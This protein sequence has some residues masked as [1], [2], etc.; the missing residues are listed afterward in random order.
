MCVCA[1]MT[2]EWEHSCFHTLVRG[3]GITPV[4]LAASSLISVTN[5][6]DRDYE[7]GRLAG[8]EGDL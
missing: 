4:P 5:I 8:V 1:H 3:E 7:K 2:S 6:P